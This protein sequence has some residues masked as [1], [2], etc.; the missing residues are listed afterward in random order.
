VEELQR[1]TL[2]DSL[3]GIFSTVTGFNNHKGI[4]DHFVA[5]VVG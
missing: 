5:A 4:A 1:A 2:D 3:Q